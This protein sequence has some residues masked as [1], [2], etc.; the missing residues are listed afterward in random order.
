V[1]R[2]SVVQSDLEEDSEDDISENVAEVKPPAFSSPS[3]RRAASGSVSSA[4]SSSKRPRLDHNVEKQLLLDIEKAGG[5][6]FLNQENFQAL[7]NLLKNP[8]RIRLYGKRG[9]PIRK[10]I[11]RRV[12]YL[13]T[14]VK[15]DYDILIR[16]YGIEP[17]KLSARQLKDLRTRESQSTPKNIH[18]PNKS[19]QGDVSD[20]EDF[21]GSE[22]ESDHHQ[23]RSPSKTSKPNLVSKAAAKKAPAKREPIEE[24]AKK[25]AAK[26]TAAPKTMADLN[27]TMSSTH[28]V[29]N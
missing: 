16:S 6:S 28:L 24:E 10:K 4:N 23:F 3:A 19:A 26:P 12:T 13:K 8:D 18:L 27:E 21:Y 20:L 7:A 22:S 2:G 25:P 9:E 29:V 11:S 5:I 1:S 14:L 15:A 17:A